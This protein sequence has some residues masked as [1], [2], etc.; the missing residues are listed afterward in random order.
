MSRHGGHRS[1]RLAAARAQGVERRVEFPV[2]S[3]LALR[4]MRKATSG[5]PAAASSARAHLRRIVRGRARGPL[6]PR[7]GHLAFRQAHVQGLAAAANGRREAARLVRHQ[8]QRGVARRLLQRFE[9]GVRGAAVHRLRGKNQR[10]LAPADGVGQLQGLGQSAH[11]VD[12]DLR[13]Q[14]VLLRVLLEG[15]DVAVRV[16]PRLQQV[17]RSGKRRR[18]GSRPSRHS[19]RP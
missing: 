3:R 4:S 5:L 11:L 8:Q 9:Q 2:G 17:R 15:H 7:Q 13:A 19:R 18:P 14:L 16:R 1:G 10:G 12:H 6:Q